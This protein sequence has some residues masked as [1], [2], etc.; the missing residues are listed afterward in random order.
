MLLSLPKNIL[1][2]ENSSISYNS[3][4][5]EISI[6][7]QHTDFIDIVNSLQSPSIL[8]RESSNFHEKN[9]ILNA[10]ISVEKNATLNIDSNDLTWIKIVPSKNTPNAIKVDGS[11]KVDSKN[12]FLEFTNK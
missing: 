11:L 12:N 6:A 4:E 2:V 7:C 1:A 9:W 5:N 3:I 8:Q 10:G